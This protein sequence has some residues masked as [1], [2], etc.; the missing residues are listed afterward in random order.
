MRNVTFRFTLSRIDSAGKINCM[1]RLVSLLLILLLVLGQPLIHSHAGSG[2][3]E[4]G[5]HDLRPHVHLA[6]HSHQHDAPHGDD[7]HHHEG[8]HPRDSDN[9]EQSPEGEAVSP[10]VDHDSDAIYLLASTAVSASVPSF[11]I[12][13]EVAQTRSVAYF[14]QF[15]APD[16]NCSCG[17]PDRY[18]TL[19]VFLLTAS[20]RL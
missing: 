5:G 13:F 16:R 8:D 19:P 17:P 4:P 18:A 7:E 2:V 9:H 12:D 20:L 6:A 1:N 15:D 14:N 10:L 3:F 11:S